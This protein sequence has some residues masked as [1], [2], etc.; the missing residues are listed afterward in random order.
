[1][2]AGNEYIVIV[3]NKKV[4]LKLLKIEMGQNQNGNGNEPTYKLTFDG[5]VQS[6][7]WDYE[8]ECGISIKRNYP[9]DL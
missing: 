1:M 2:V 9:K 8:Y 5:V 3:K 4:I 7:M 6:Q